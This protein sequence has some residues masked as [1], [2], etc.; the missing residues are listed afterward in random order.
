MPEGTMFMDVF[1]LL[2][3]IKVNIVVLVWPIACSQH[4]ERTPKPPISI[5]SPG[6]GG[7]AE[8]VTFAL[9]VQGQDLGHS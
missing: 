2:L 9:H 1:G 5:V 8:E 4:A 7:L 6:R 3:T